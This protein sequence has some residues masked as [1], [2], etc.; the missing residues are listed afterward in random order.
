MCF[1]IRHTI[2]LDEGVG[3]KPHGFANLALVTIGLLDGPAHWSAFDNQARLEL[4]FRRVKHRLAFQI[5]NLGDFAH[6]GG[7]NDRRWHDECNG[8]VL[9]VDDI[10]TTETH[11]LKASQALSNAGVASFAIAW[12][13]G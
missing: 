4:R 6:K 9:L 10:V 12:I 3:V 2:R 7:R 8:T 13:G 5:G 11:L 1:D